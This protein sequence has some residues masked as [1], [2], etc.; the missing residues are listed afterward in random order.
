MMK[1]WNISF[2]DK[3]P[4]YIRCTAFKVKGWVLQTGRW[5]I[6]IVG[7]SGSN[8]RIFYE[9]ILEQRNVAIIFLLEKPVFLLLLI[10]E[11][12]F[13]SAKYLILKHRMPITC[14]KYIEFVLLDDQC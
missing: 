5:P 7:P 4:A 14:T 2:L 8:S 10:N 3:M 12:G 9:A 11:L 1:D 13:L 6:V